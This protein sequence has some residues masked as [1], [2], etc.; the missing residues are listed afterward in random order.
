M[1]RVSSV[2][3]PP[4]LS[5]SRKGRLSLVFR[6][7]NLNKMAVLF[8]WLTRLLDGDV[9]VESLWGDQKR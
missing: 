4:L 7:I 6:S 8:T 5:L 3:A 9:G 1:V 2:C